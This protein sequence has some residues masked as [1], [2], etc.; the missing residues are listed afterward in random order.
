VLQIAA[1]CGVRVELDAAQVN[2]P[3]ESGRIIDDNLFR[4][5]TGRE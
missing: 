1:A 2:D 5:A 4:R 3:G